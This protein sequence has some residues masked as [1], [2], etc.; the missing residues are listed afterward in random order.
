[1][2]NTDHLTS[3]LA[4]RGPAAFAELMK[5][6]RES[7]RI[8]LN[9]PLFVPGLFQVEGYATE[10]IGRLSALK[11]G[12][13]ELTDRVNARMQRAAGLAQRLSGATPPHVAVVIDEAV[14]RRVVGDREVMREQ[15]GQ[16]KALLELPTVEIGIVPLAHGAHQGLIGSFEVHEDGHG[17]DA[18][19]FEAAHED[20]ILTSDES[21]VDHYRGIVENMMASV[22][23]GADA[24]ALLETISSEL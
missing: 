8:S 4:T 13:Q 11:A 2:A 18:V 20:E 6:E 22:V 21:E 17:D 10:M 1:M 5:R 19:Y 12:D 9:Q 15:V 24:R 7:V 23:S 3:S 16:L 14:L